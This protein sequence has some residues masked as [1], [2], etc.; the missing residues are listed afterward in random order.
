MSRGELA[1]VF[2]GGDAR[3]DE[4]LTLFSQPIEIDQRPNHRDQ[5]RQ[6]HQAE[7]NEDQSVK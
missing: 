6:C 5:Q 1:I 4:L 3:D 7:S 2:G